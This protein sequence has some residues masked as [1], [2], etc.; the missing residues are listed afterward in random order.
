[1]TLKIEREGTLIA[2]GRSSDGAY[3]HCNVKPGYHWE[4]RNK[5]FYRIFCF[6]KNTDMCLGWDIWTQSLSL[7]KL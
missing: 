6:D 1:M 7:H 4:V 2:W 5:G 3:S